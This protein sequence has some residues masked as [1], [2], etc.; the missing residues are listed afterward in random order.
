MPM[1]STTVG[2]SKELT[3]ADR[4]KCKYSPHKV[5]A[6]TQPTTTTTI[7]VAMIFRMETTSTCFLLS[8]KILSVAG[9]WLSNGIDV[10]YSGRNWF[11]I[12]NK[13]II[14]ITK[15][16]SHTLT[17]FIYLCIVN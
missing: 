8:N 13:E 16:K 9:Y 7:S 11:S 17:I 3:T 5:A 6:S 12:F 10:F 4:C 15:K 14:S 2:Y 1:A